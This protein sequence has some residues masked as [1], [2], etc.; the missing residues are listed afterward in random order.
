MLQGGKK[1]NK[2]TEEE[3]DGTCHRLFREVALSEEREEGDGSVATVACFVAQR[4][5]VAPQQSRL[6]LMRCSVAP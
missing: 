1:K 3:G 5:S 4:C 6:L 2:T